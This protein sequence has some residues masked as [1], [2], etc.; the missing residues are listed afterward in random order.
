MDGTRSALIVASDEYAD[1]GL[2]RLRAPASDARAL[3]AV[4]R[5][6]EIGAFEVRTLLNE[7]AHV[8]NLKVEEFFADRRPG[9]LLL[10]HFSGHG[11]K[12]EDGELY[13]AASNTVL[14]RLGATA[15]AAEFVRRRMSRSRSRR[16]VLLLDCCYAGAFER[17]LAA[18]AGTDVGIE[19]QLGGRGRAVIT[20]S[21]AMEYAFEAGE[22]TGTPDVP[23]SVFTSALVQGLETGDADRDQDGLV[24]LDELY[25]YV[26]DQVRAITPN[27]TPGK[28]V[29]GVEGELYIARRSRP[30]TAP[31]P[32][33]AELQ[34]AIDNPL[35]GIRAAAVKELAGMLH[36]RHAGMALAARLALEQLTHDDSRAVAAAAITALGGQKPPALALPVTSIDFGQ[37][38]RHTQSPERRIPLRNAG[39]GTL[40]ARATTS[41]SWLKLRQAGDELVVAVDTGE[42]GDYEGTV[43]VDSDGGTATISVQARIVPALLP[44]ATTTGTTHPEPVPD[45]SVGA[46]PRPL[47]DPVL[48]ATPSAM[49]PADPSVAATSPGPADPAAGWAATGLDGE[50]A[51]AA[52]GGHRALSPSRDNQV[53]LPEGLPPAV[54]ADGPRARR[55]RRVMTAAAAVVVVLGTLAV[56][57][58]Q[59]HWPS[60][61]F[62]HP[63]PQQTLTW[64]AAEAP[65]PADAVSSPRKGYAAQLLGVACPAAGTCVAAGKYPTQGG[66]SDGLIE[67]LSHGTWSPALAGTPVPPGAAAYPDPVLG[68]VTCR[69]PGICMAAGVNLADGANA[70]GLIEALSSAVWTPSRVGPA[71]T[72]GRDQDVNLNGLA[73]PAASSCVAVGASYCCLTAVTESQALVA[74]LTNGAWTSADPPLPTDAVVANRQAGLSGIACWSPVSCLA[75]G[76]YTDTDGNGQGLIET[77][78]NGTWTPMKVALPSGAAKTRQEAKLIAVAC[79]AA[80]DC[81]AVGQY[82][83]ADGNGQG[84]IETLVNGTWT[85]MKVAL[86]SGAA[87]TRQE[88]TVNAVACAAAGD[89]VAVGQYTDADGN[90]QGLIETLVNGT[91]TPMKVALPSGAAKTHQEATLNA[92]AC[93]AEGNCVAVGQYTDGNKSVQALIETG[94]AN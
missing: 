54:Q 60:A 30:V 81:V 50:R 9:D 36:G 88:A 23:P 40:N 72:A 73:C 32:L 70:N 46:G 63:A 6:P 15:V 49:A 55:L 29:F 51:P 11:V 5:D 53:G 12:D 34:Q 38:P 82:T 31:V 84:L 71:A 78:V 91:W 37:L 39:G 61:V 62:G 33:P 43:T 1:P 75:V 3:A 47:Q 68:A 64:S 76:R 45:T 4:L 90:G 26:Y 27:Q 87:K 21:S 92:V 79:A 67:T 77:L 48:A 22:L 85:P 93:A 7:P 58:W 66:H 10:V 25:D 14:G 41:A 83:D 16:V 94:M 28:W 44:P 19:Q 86:P 24:G 18:R 80:G 56:T 20:A 8:V 74:T 52:D 13:F 57:G 35:A 42:A 17:G 2:R 59:E 65:L 89:C 69:A